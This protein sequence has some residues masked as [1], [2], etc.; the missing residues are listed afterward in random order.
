MASFFFKNV[1]KNDA[2]LLWKMSRF[3]THFEK[4]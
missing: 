2:E 3:V 1:G 4:V